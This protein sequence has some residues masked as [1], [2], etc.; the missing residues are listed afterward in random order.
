MQE[1]LKKYI[2]KNRERFLNELFELL[3]IPSVSTDPKHKEQVLEAAGYVKTH[4]ENAGADQCGILS[5][6]G[7][8]IVYGEKILDPGLPTA[9]VYGHYDVQPADPYELWDT[10]PFEPVIRDNKIFARGA[11]DDKGQMF[12]HIK[13]FEYLN[14]TGQLPCNVK[15]LI[16]GE[17]EIGSKNL[18]PF[19]REN[20]EKLRADFVLISDTAMLGNDHPSFTIGLRG[21]CFLEAEVTGPNRDLHSGIYGGAVANPANV[22][23]GMINRLKDECGQITI[24]G[25]Y[26]KVKEPPPEEREAMKRIPVTDDTFKKE[27][28]IKELSGEEGFS[29]YER[30]SV[31]PSLDINGIWGGY[32]GE[33]AKTIIPSKASAKISMRL[34]PD[35]DEDEISRK[36]AAYIESL[37]PATVKVKTRV[38]YGASPVLVPVNLTEY[39]AASKAYEDS[40]GKTPVPVRTGGS[41]PVVAM[42]EQVLGLKSI[43]MGFGL[44]SDAIHSHNE[45]FGLF[46]FFKGIE[47]LPLFYHHLKKSQE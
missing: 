34:V 6:Q 43:M 27:L 17:E 18:E 13:A 40:F 4:L 11:S 20:Q 33:G 26:D 46:N 31:R 19:L 2:E 21:L 45:H 8:P 25:F 1:E 42:F 39:K 15:F 29:T 23:A 36:A 24:P 12:M 32:T 5:T 37:A 10:P 47:T 14:N 9:L 41:I 44:D 22:L 3:K 16:E 35:Q 28:D 30:T 7:H 38:L